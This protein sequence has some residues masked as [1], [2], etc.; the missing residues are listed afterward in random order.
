MNDYGVI[1][2]INE[3]LFELIVVTKVRFFFLLDDGWGIKRI[4]A[5]NFDDRFS[6]IG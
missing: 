4:A 6:D 1:C 3:N 5:V 2:V